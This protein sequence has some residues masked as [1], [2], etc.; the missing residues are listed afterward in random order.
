MK[1]EESLDRETLLE[2]EHFLDLGFEKD[3][4]EE[5][6]VEYEYNRI[7]NSNDI[8]DFAEKFHVEECT[9]ETLGTFLTKKEDTKYWLKKVLEITSLGEF[10]DNNHL[11]WRVF[12]EYKLSILHYFVKKI[13]NKKKL[14]KVNYHLKEISKLLEDDDL[15]H[16]I[17]TEE[18]FSRCLYE[19]I[20]DLEEK[21]N[22]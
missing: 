20:D 14:K 8:W 1:K 22:K 7:E 18:V 9:E 4:V 6:L 16:E 5:F 13:E 11:S 21:A 10:D 19:I 12:M 2:L 15:M 3:M 17:A